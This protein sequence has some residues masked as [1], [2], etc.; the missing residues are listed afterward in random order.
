MTGRG[1]TFLFEGRRVVILTDQRLVI[2]LTFITSPD[3]IDSLTNFMAKFLF[4]CYG[5][6]SDLFPFWRRTKSISNYS[7]ICL[8]FTKGY[9]YSLLCSRVKVFI[10]TNQHGFVKRRSTVFNFVFY[11]IHM[12]ST[13]QYKSSRCT[14]T[15]R[16]HSTPSMIDFP[17]LH[18][19]STFPWNRTY[20]RE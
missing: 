15:S 2:S 20:A 16:L 14:P 7:F 1:P 5:S 4:V 18:S 13:W 8:I 10:S 6:A 17:S 9:L 3:L 11:T 19:H 12:W